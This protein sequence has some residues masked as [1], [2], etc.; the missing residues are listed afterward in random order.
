MIVPILLCARYKT[1]AKRPRRQYLPLMELAHKEDPDD[2]QIC[3]WLGRE[4]MWAKRHERAANC[5]SVTWAC[6]P[7][8]GP[9]SAQRPCAIWRGCNPTRRCSGSTRHEWKRRTGERF[10]SIWRK[11][12][13]AK[14][15]WSN[16]FWA[17]TNGI[18]K[19]HRT[20]SYLDDNHCWGFRLFDL[21]AIAVLAPQRDGSRGGMGTESA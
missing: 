14:A 11:S 1:T 12:F 4:Y 13:T 5:C 8:L 20:G 10:G 18:E 3:F 21:G 15:D 6:R 7:A 9:R 17:C 16:L 19:T 2:A